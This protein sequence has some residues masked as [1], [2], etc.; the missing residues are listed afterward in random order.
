MQG[1]NNLCFCKLN[2]TKKGSV[3]TVPAKKKFDRQYIFSNMKRDTLSISAFVNY[4]QLTRI[5]DLKT[6]LLGN[7]H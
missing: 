6:D 2:S 3:V 4:I 5:F 7:M 1:T